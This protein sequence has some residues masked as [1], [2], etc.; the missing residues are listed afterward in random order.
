MKILVVDD[1]GYSRHFHTRLLQKFGYQTEIAE[2][3]P[4]A[5]KLLEC[6]LT[7]NV[8][9]TD[10]M[11][12]DM[13]GVEL[14]QRSQRISRIVDGRTAEPPAYIL[15]TALRPGND[16]SQQKDLDKI[17]MAKE[18]GFVDMLFK[19]IEPESLKATLET[20]KYA[21]SRTQI[22]TT[23]ALRKLSETI[24]NLIRE[25]Q[26]DNAGRFVDEIRQELERLEA[27]AAQL[28]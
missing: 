17:R 8:V 1:V 23:S 20:I 21:S 28:I 14:F 10:L 11:M 2:T 7:I 6:D 12:R 18:I 13:D 19:P 25:K 4:Q 16:Q 22:D 9:L 15:M 24:D 27:F 3:G 26:H 5:L